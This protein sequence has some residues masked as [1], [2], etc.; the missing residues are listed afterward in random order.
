MRTKPPNNTDDI[1]APNMKNN[2]TWNTC[3]ECGKSWKDDI[4]TPGL[5]HRTRL[6]DKCYPIV[7]ARYENERN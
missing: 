4:S 5:L 7:K 6:C 1:T 2:E 3:P